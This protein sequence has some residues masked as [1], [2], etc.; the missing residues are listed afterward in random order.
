MTADEAG[1]FLIAF[2]I[3]VLVFGFGFAVINAWQETGGKF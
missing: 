3:G 2:A 1:F